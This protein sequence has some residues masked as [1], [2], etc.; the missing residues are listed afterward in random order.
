MIMTR[1]RTQTALAESS[2]SRSR[3]EAEINSA[4]FSTTSDAEIGDDG[5][6][7]AWGW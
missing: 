5:S 1:A 6:P 3:S 7:G 2:S 4:E